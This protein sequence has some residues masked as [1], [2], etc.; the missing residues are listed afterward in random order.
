[1]EAECSMLW[2]TRETGYDGREHNLQ[3]IRTVVSYDRSWLRFQRKRGTPIC[4]KL[5]VYKWEQ[6]WKRKAGTKDME[7]R[8]LED[9][10]GELEY[11]ITVLWSTLEAVS[12]AMEGED[13]TLET[14]RGAVRGASDQARRLQQD[15]QKML[16]ELREGHPDQEAEG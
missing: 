15:L 7:R 2:S 13:R 11:D 5:D 9:R 6:S 16:K 1:M 8:V 4:D 3:P 14:Y 10:I 12:D